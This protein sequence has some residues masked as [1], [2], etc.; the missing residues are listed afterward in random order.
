MHACMHASMLSNLFSDTGSITEPGNANLTGLVGQ[1]TPGILLSLHP[2]YCPA[3]GLQAYA[4][5]PGFYMGSGGIQTHIFTDCMTH[6]LPSELPS[7]LS[8]PII[9][10]DMFL[11]T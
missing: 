7:H 9:S 11:M 1:C 4:T 5:I 10:E 8:L 6:T 2:T 3:L